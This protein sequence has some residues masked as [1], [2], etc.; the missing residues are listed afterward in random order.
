MQPSIIIS[1]LYRLDTGTIPAFLMGNEHL[2]QE[3]V[4]GSDILITTRFIIMD[5]D[6]IH[7]RS[8]IMEALAI[9]G[10]D[11]FYYNNWYTPVVI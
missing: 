1:R 6:T 7:V 3:E 8:F 11:P 2:W 4:L 9:T 10:Y 5:T